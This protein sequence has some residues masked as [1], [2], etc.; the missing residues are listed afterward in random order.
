MKFT[1]LL[2]SERSGSNLISKLVD[3]HSEF[4]GPAPTH[5]VRLF[6]QNIL[7]YGD[8]DRDDN[9]SVLLGDVV[10]SLGSQLGKWQK[11]FTIDNLWSGVGERS[12]RAIIRYVYESE[13]R[14][15]GKR[16]VFLKENHA[17]NF[18]SFYSIAFP[19]AKYVYLVRDPRDVCLSWKVSP[20][21]PGGIEKGAE[22]WKADQENSLR[23]FGYLRESARVKLVKYEELVADTTRVAEDLCEFLGVGFEPSMLDYHKKT[24]TRQNADRL[25]DWQNLAKPVMTANFNKYRTELSSAEIGLIEQIC[26]REMSLLGYTP[27]HPECPDL[28]QLRETVGRLE[29]ETVLT[30]REQTEIEKEVR[31]RRLDNIKTVLN[32]RLPLT[33]T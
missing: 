19:D 9:W 14:A 24:L 32:R 3:A 4:I 28:E 11:E 15:Q 18:V 30:D 20:N 12:L 25:H 22:T 10:E 16:Q 2:C 27:D 8:L 23:V 5:M 17:Y 33:L 21:H 26:Q 31:V 7:N 6:A 29:K 1:F 13:A